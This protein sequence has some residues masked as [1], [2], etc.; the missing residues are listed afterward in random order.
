[1]YRLKGTQN[2]SIFK[3]NHIAGA[4]CIEPLSNVNSYDNLY[5]NEH[6]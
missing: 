4:Y 5:S 2:I 1:M 6:Q 3:R